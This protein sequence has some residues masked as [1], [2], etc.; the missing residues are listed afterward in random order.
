MKPIRAQ[1]H[2]ED[3]LSIECAIVRFQVV[4]M[5]IGGM[6]GF[7]SRCY[8]VAIADNGGIIFAE[9]DNFTIKRPSELGL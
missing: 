9:Y 3:G 5:G 2:E 4:P 8:A 1:Y 7:Y 6:D